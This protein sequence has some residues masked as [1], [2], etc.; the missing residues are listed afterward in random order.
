MSLIALVGARESHIYL[1]RYLQKANC[2][3]RLLMGGLA[4]VAVV[5]IYT[6]VMQNQFQD[7]NNRVGKGFAVLGIYLFVIG[8]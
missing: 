6:A 7:T 1:T 2:N 5:D 3:R 4:W 8:Y